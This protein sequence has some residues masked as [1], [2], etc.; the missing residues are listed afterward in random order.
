MSMLSTR[1]PVGASRSLQG[2]G[3][4]VVVGAVVDHGTDSCFS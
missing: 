3:A 1:L 4:A 2:D